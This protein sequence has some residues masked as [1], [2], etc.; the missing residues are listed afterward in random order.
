M[1]KAV[2][3]D[4][5]GTLIPDIPYNIDPV[6]IRLK[7]EALPG[8]LKLQN[9]GFLIIIVSNQS[10]VARGYFNEQQLLPVENK[11]AQLLSDGGIQLNGFLYCPHHPEG[12][13]K[14]FAINCEC[15]KP[16]AGML[17]QAASRWDIDLSRSWMLGD[18]LNDVEAGNRAG[19]KTVLINTGGETEWQAGDYRKP[20]FIARNITQA[21]DYILKVENEREQLGGL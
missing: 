18:I 20:D 13:I 3:I 1:T 2:F 12:T 21:A 8:L 5:D 15:R 6:L 17:L 4:K 14:D 9:D 16:K 11:I 10:G 19:S 7:D